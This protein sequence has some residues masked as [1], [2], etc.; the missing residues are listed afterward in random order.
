M[1]KKGNNKIKV[2]A[3]LLGLAIS[4]SG[5]AKKEQPPPPPPQPKPAVK[6]TPSSAAVQQQASSAKAGQAQFDFSAKKDPFK[7][8]AVEVAQGKPAAVPGKAEK[9]EEL[10]PI[11][12]YDLSKFRVSGIIVG[13]KENS[14]LIVD[15]KGK[16]YVVKQGMLIGSN[17][18]RITRIASTYLEVTEQYREEN[19]RTRKKTTRLTLPQK[20]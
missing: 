19:G 3:L 10:L 17:N 9:A 2:L 20:K 18:G 16:G 6:P 8:Y 4:L 11:Q 15:P 1:L 7:P 14:A 12:S 13:M 5:C